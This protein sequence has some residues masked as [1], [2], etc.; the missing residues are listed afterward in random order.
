MTTARALVRPAPDTVRAA[1]PIRLDQGDLDLRPPPQIAAAAAVAAR[2]GGPTSHPAGEPALR[3]RLAQRLRLRTGLHWTPEQVLIT[4]GASQALSL[5]LSTL[6]R[7]GAEVLHPDPGWARYPALIRRYGAVP[8]GYDVSPR[9]DFQPSLEEIGRLITPR[10]RAIVINSPGNP[11]GAVL[12]RRTMQQLDDLCDRRGLFLI[13]DEAY[14]ELVFDGECVGA[15]GL[16]GRR[17]LSVHSFSKTYAMADWRVGYLVGDAQLV[18][19]LAAAQETD[20]TRVS[21]ISQAGAMAALSGPQTYPDRLREILRG[22][23]DLAVGV[24]QA[25]GLDVTPPAAGFFVL[26][27]IAP[28]LCAETACEDIRRCGVVVAPGTDFGTRLPSHVRV[29]LTVN[30]A[31]LA[32][33]VQRLAEWAV[34]TGCGTELLHVR[35]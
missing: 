7:P 32:A 2:S 33:G 6:L 1:G 22:R 19:A 31:D 28:G 29:S 26:M 18:A 30:E 34:L 5:I 14:D 17:T 8:V 23:R 9:R 20:L 25:A 16:G 10:T 3:H 12:P 21:P 27:P 11:T 35:R 24:L 15:S 4:A 13:S